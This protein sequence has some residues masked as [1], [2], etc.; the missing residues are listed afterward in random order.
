MSYSS[1]STRKHGRDFE[2]TIM[3]QE[4]VAIHEQIVDL[5]EKVEIND[6][7]HTK[8]ANFLHQEILSLRH[9]LAEARASCPHRM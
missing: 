5:K 3:R 6:A 2:L 7:I 9:Q 4:I 8:E 1:A